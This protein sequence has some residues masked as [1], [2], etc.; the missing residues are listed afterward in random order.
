[1]TRPDVATVA[2]VY[3]LLVAAARAQSNVAA[4][5]GGTEL[6]MRANETRGAEYVPAN[7]LA[8]RVRVWADTAYVAVPRLR[9]GVPATLCATSARGDGGPL[10][11]YPSAG[12]QTP[13]NCIG[14]Q[15]AADIEL[16]HLGRLWTLDRG[17]AAA[18]GYACDPKLFVVDTGTGRVVRSAVMPPQAYDAARSVLSGLAVDLKTLTAVVAD[19]RPDDPGFV[20]YDYPSG[21]YRRF[22][23]SVLARGD[24]DGGGRRTGHGDDDDDDGYDEAALTAS[25]IDD[26][27]YFTTARLRRVYAIP[28]SVFAAPP[29]YGRD[30]GHY[31]SARGPVNGTATAAVMD[32]R[33]TLYVAVRPGHRV[34]AWDTLRGGFAAAATAVR[35]VRLDWVSG[36]ALDARGYLWIV[37]SSYREFRGAGAAADA[38]VFRLYRGATAFA[39]QEAAANLTADGGGDGAAAAA[40][41]GRDAATVGPAAVV[42]CAA[43][44]LLLRTACRDVR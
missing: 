28:L 2:A 12:L 18:G 3:G 41:R 24:G 10:R 44:A 25:P 14:L 38:R 23:C 20:T 8:F 31:A 6:R 39:L 17:R 30:V 42:C 22:R 37:T 40:G 43:A 9:G 11:P 26:Q 1:M 34:M 36:L 33:G 5:W 27:L 4:P 35:D 29:L 15:D 32:V 21:V 19:L 13:G 16:D 7:N